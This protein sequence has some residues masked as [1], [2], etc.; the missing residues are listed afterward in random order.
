MPNCARC[1]GHR[2]T[3]QEVFREKTGRPAFRKI[4]AD[5][6]DNCRVIKTHRVYGLTAKGT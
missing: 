4:N 3:A 6:W 2:V 5:L 1:Q